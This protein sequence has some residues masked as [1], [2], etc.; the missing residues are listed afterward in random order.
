MSA[1]LQRNHV[2]NLA[3]RDSL[4]A[5]EQAKAIADPWFKSQALAWVAR[6]SEKACLKVATMAAK[7][8][9]GCDDAYKK[10]AVK[11]WGIAALAERKF[12]VEAK[13]A[14]R[15][16]LIESRSVTPHSSRAEALILLLQ[17]ALLIGNKDA[18]AVADE[19]KQ[20]CGDDSHW[21]CKR[22]VRD[23]EK[24]IQGQLKPRPFFW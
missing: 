12:L 2:C 19:L 13:D 3:K 14:L 10:T 1:T 17:A 18:G 7:T 11:S 20:C 8:A 9:G 4:K 16:A 23:S 22:A 24:L 15:S 5:L 6:Y 21:R